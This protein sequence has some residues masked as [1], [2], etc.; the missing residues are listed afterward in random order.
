MYL[1][2]DDDKKH[3]AAFD[4]SPMMALT[5]L[6]GCGMPWLYQYPKSGRIPRKAGEP[7]ERER[8][9][10]RESYWLSAHSP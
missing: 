10:E 3:D 5:I 8:E 2:D 4:N 9:R 1:H 7:D 6:S